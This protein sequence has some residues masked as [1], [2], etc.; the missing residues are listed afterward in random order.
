MEQS[1]R[2]VVSL[3][4]GSLLSQMSDAR[5]VEYTSRENISTPGRISI[6]DNV[7]FCT[8]LSITF[9]FHM[10]RLLIYSIYGGFVCVYVLGG[11]T[12]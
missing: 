11:G 10:F 2:Q 5:R 3:G 8:Y 6:G 4:F 9:L 1:V 12:G 7:C